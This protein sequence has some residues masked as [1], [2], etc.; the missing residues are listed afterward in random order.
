[1]YFIGI[2]A[3]GRFGTPPWLGLRKLSLAK[4]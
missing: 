2:Y 4:F 3:G 1:M